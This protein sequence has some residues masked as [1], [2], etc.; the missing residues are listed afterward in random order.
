MN[1][2]ERVEEIYRE[3]ILIRQLLLGDD[4]GQTK[5]IVGRLNNI[6]ER[7][8]KMEDKQTKF[9]KYIYM[10][11]GAFALITFI[12]SVILSYYTVIK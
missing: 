1:I 3:I 8:Q 9:T 12:C 6:E 7:Q 5:G 2:N 4:S 11:H 10:F